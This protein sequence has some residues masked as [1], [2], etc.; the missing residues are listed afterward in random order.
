MLVSLKRPTAPKAA[1][2]VRPEAVAV[3]CDTSGPRDRL[4]TRLSSRDTRRKAC[5]R[6]TK[7]LSSR[8]IGAI[9]TGKTTATSSTVRAH[10]MMNSVQLSRAEGR[11]LS[12]TSRSPV[13]RERMRPV[14]WD[15]K[16]PLVA[17]M[18][19][20]KTRSCSLRE[21]VVVACAK[22]MP[23]STFSTSTAATEPA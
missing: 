8:H 1:M 10:C 11:A 4:S 9:K 2:L 17:R 21:A 14:G 23:C 20:E 13:K 16:K 15:S 18:M 12:S 19:E 5:V 3:T 6:K 22:S 7:A